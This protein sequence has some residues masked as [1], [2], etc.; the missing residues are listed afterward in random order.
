M[1][2]VKRKYDKAGSIY[3]KLASDSNKYKRSLGRVL[4]ALIPVH[5][6]KLQETLKVL[7]D[8]MATDKMEQFDGHDNAVKYLIKAFVS[9]EMNELTLALR[10]CETAIEIL[11]ETDPI[12]KLG[13]EGYHAFFLGANNQVERVEEIAGILKKKMNKKDRTR[14]RSYWTL[15]GWCELSKGNL[16]AAIPNFE[17]AVKEDEDFLTLYLLAKTYLDTGRL[18]EAVKMFEK[19]IS[20]YDLYRVALGIYAVKAYYLLV[21]AYEKSGWNRKA[22][23]KYE[24]FLEIRKDADPGIKEVKIAKQRLAK[25]KGMIDK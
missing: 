2:L 21:S 16:E 23:A 8:G 18:G 13:W 20:S 1:Y 19:A 9:M 6:G 15:L 14:D 11:F 24:D 10:E 7:A 12:N 22:A 25:L 5:Q 17:K 3:R 4:L